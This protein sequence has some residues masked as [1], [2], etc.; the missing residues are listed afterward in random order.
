MPH[1]SQDSR[2]TLDPVIATILL[3]RSCHW[4]MRHCIAPKTRGG[5]ELNSLKKIKGSGLLCEHFQTSFI[6]FIWDSAYRRQRSSELTHLAFA[7]KTDPG[8]TPSN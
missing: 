4:P 5:I 7:H 2:K 1:S 6:S 8:I 3:R